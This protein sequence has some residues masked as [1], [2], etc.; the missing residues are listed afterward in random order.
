M[1]NV[2]LDNIATNCNI[3]TVG[4]ARIL[5]SYSTPVAVTILR[6]G[7]HKYQTSE[8][9]S[10]TTSKHINLAGYSDAEKVSQDDLVKL[11]NSAN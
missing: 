4:N 7:I 9:F 10:R 1:P 3:V 11:I 6:D 5:F 8:K 2:Q